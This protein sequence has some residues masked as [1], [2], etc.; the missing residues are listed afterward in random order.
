MGLIFVQRYAPTVLLSSGT[1]TILAGGQFN[2]QSYMEIEL[3]PTVYNQPG[4]YVL[5]DYSAGS[6]VYPGSYA[7]G[8]AALTDLVIVTDTDLVNLTVSAGSLTDDTV[9]KRITVTL[10]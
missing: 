5:I 2:L 10:V 9:N 1:Q 3:D 6:F 8:Q 4:T 7:N